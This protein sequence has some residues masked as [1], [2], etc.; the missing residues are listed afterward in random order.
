MNNCRSCTVSGTMVWTPDQGKLCNT[1]GKCSP[2]MAEVAAL[3]AQQRAKYLAAGTSR[4]SL[5]R[6]DPKETKA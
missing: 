4:R 2:S 3:P 6:R 1:L 5:R